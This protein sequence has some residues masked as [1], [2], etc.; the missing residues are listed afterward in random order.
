MNQMFK[1]ARHS[2]H[3][4][5]DDDEMAEQLLT[6]YA[7]YWVT[8]GEVRRG[9]IETNNEEAFSIPEMIALCCATAYDPKRFDASK[10]K[11]TWEPTPNESLTLSTIPMSYDTY[12]Q[13]MLPSKWW[14]MNWPEEVVRYLVWRQGN[15]MIVKGKHKVVSSSGNM[16]GM[17]VQSTVKAQ[18]KP[19]GVDRRSSIMFAD[20]LFWIQTSQTLRQM[21]F[22]ELDPLGKH[23]DEERL[24][25]FLRESI[26]VE[27]MN[28]FEREGRNMVLMSLFPIGAYQ[29]HRRFY[30]TSANYYSELNVLEDSLPEKER[31]HAQYQMRGEV[32]M[33]ENQIKHYEEVLKRH[34]VEYAAFLKRHKKTPPSERPQSFTDEK[35][36]IVSAESIEQRKQRLTD[37]SN[38]V[39]FVLAFARWWQKVNLQKT[40]DVYGF[41]DHVILWQDWG[42]N[43][44]NHVDQEF[45]RDAL[46]R[47]NCIESRDG[48]ERRPL[49]VCL[50]NDLWFVHYKRRF[51]SSKSPHPSSAIRAICLW[52]HLIRLDFNGSVGDSTHIPKELEFWQ[53]TQSEK[54]AELK[55]KKLQH[56]YKSPLQIVEEESKKKKPSK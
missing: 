15:V 22:V 26:A 16:S 8:Y 29:R 14:H 20:L 49:I 33:V 55:L 3:T 35:G 24:E 43:K 18:E 17:T 32:L 40:S 51:Y 27:F 41:L 30:P 52:L 2:T 6:Q 44:S 13:W 19:P 45:D 1:N 34:E 28:E 36:L 38:E 47:L 42:G 4:N 25:R 54:D 46:P 5:K 50:G 10:L 37:S 56:V 9:N 53:K 39:W 12:V 11:M 31:Q 21:G 7:N 48:K 23:D